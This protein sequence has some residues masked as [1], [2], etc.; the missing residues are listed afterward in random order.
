MQKTSD[1]IWQDTQHQVLFELIDRIKE[2][3]F[4]PDILV[5]LKLYAEHHFVLEEVYMEKL[6]YPH[7]DAHIR[8]HDR[9]REELEAMMET[10]PS[11]H[12]SLQVS[13]S[14]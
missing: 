7:K 3:P 9:F 13:L 8:A 12:E 4:D 10:D 11:M 6:E 1:V 5:R 14:D 2:V